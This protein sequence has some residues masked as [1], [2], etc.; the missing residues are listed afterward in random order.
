MKADTTIELI[1]EYEFPFILIYVHNLFSLL[2]EV[3]DKDLRYDKMFEKLSGIKQSSSWDIAI[4]SKLLYN[5]H[6]KL[7]F[8]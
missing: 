4:S 5:T 2:F 1:S 3:I 8:S 6:L 7:Y